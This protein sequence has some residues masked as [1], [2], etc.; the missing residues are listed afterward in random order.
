[1]KKAIQGPPFS[2]FYA[3]EENILSTKYIHKNI[4]V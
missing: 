1:M 3:S 2:L 4:S